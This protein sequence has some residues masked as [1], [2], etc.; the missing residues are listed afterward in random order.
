MPPW[1]PPHPWWSHHAAAGG[2][3]A[4]SSRVCGAGAGAGGR[5]VSSLV[6]GPPRPMVAAP[7]LMAA[8]GHTDPSGHV[9]DG[10]SRPGRIILPAGRR[11]REEESE[12]GR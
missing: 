10:Y 11:G 7:P 8:L 3:A 2:R 5:P 9:G 4:A 6:V 1:C 12:E